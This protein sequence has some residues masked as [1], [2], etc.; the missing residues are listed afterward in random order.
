MLQQVQ[1]AD[2]TAVVCGLQGAQTHELRHLGS[3]GGLDTY[4]TGAAPWHVESSRTKDQTC[5]LCIGG[6]GVDS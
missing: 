4:G 3:G 5:V 2:S 6:G 1:H